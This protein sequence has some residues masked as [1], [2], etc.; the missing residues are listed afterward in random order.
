[1]SI[2]KVKDSGRIVGWR[3][4][5]GKITKTFKTRK[6]AEAFGR[7][8]QRKAEAVAEPVAE[9]PKRTWLAWLKRG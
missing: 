5:Q 8:P 2:T 9:Q 6:E 7:G 4:T 3:A 1:V